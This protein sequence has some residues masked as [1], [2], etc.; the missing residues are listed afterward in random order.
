MRNILLDN[1]VDEF[2]QTLANETFK[3]IHATGEKKHLQNDI[4]SRFVS[5][6]LENTILYT[7]NK[8][9]DS[10]QL[11]EEEMYTYTKEDFAAVKYQLQNAIAKGFEQAFQLHANKRPEYYCAINLVPE[12]LNK[13]A[14]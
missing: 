10:K 5:Y 13:K 6:F 9:A 8:Y 7:L 3:L 14:C 2:A 12:P 11:T 4:T 1:F